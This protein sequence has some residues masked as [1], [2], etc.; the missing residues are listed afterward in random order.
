MKNGVYLLLGS[1]LG[2]QEENLSLA[3]QSI[4]VIS[5][6]RTESSI[7]ETQAWG[8][9]RQPDFLNQVIQI[10]FKR[11]P[12]E[13]LGQLQEIENKM[14]RSRT[15]KWGPRI[16]DIDILFFEQ[17]V[18]NETDLI[19]PHPGIALRRFTLLP[20]AEIAP[21]FIHPT[22]IKNCNQLLKECTDPS[23]VILWKHSTGEK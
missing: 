20:L 6:I 14:G 9:T 23:G 15:E 12:R 10:S 11:S 17:L 13:L 18:L 19:I 4:Q 8:N 22:L 7:Y 16:I 5:P 2:K 21:E 1:N 3:R